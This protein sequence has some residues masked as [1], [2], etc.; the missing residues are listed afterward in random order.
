MGWLGVLM[1][2]AA[3]ILLYRADSLPLMWLAIAITATNFWS[4]GIMHNQAVGAATQ[5]PGYRGGFGDFTE[6]DIAGVSS[7]L[8]IVNMATT[9]GLIGLLVTSL[10]FNF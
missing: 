8:T 1:G 4:Y 7:R 6:A 2:V 5:R 3:S 10:V 9:L